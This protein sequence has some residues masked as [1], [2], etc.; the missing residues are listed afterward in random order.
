MAQDSDQQLK[1]TCASNDPGSAECIGK[2][3]IRSETLAN[4][5]EYNPGHLMQPLVKSDNNIKLSWTPIMRRRYIGNAAAKL[6]WMPLEGREV[7]YYEAFV[8]RNYKK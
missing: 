2:F 3:I 8:F 1:V 6:S 5:W 4:T 7:V